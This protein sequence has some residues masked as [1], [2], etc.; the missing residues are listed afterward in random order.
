MKWSDYVKMKEDPDN[1]LKQ[2]C[3]DKV[4]GFFKDEE[5]TKLWMET[6]NP[7]LGEISPIQMMQLG[8][9]QKLMQFIDSSLEGNRV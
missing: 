4:N 9:Y 5:K 8:R 1:Y 7:L 3:Y 6:N 2:M